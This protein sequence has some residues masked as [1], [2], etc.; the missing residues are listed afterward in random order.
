LYIRPAI[1]LELGL[2]P[3]LV[4]NP[5]LVASPVSLL[6]V[7]HLSLSHFKVPFEALLS[8]LHHSTLGCGHTSPQTLIG[9]Q[10]LQALRE[11]PFIAYKPCH[12]LLH[13]HHTL[14]P[15]DL[16]MEIIQW[17]AESMHPFAIVKDQGFQCLMKT[18][19]LGLYI[20]LPK[21]VP[22]DTKKVFAC[23]CKRIA[24]MLQV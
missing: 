22:Q 2:K 15:L 11:N 5:R 9:C 6:R 10:P 14:R 23:C 7:P 3:N 1:S 24:K 16:N 8:L 4:F 21:T 12:L 17:V 13:A 18:G 20:P 19:R